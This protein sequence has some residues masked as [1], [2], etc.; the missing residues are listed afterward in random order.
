VHY[1]RDILKPRS[2]N[3]RGL[4]HE[5]V[6][7]ILEIDQ[8]S[9]LYKAAG[10]GALEAIT[11]LLDAGENVDSPLTLQLVDLDSSDESNF[12]FEGCS[13]LHLAS[14]FGNPRARNE[15]EYN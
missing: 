13:P 1:H 6:R 8:L 7:P 12:Y 9:P 2:A 5:K 3:I 11:S 14:W 15:Y 4:Y 10:K